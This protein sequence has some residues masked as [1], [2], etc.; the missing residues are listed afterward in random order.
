MDTSDEQSRKTSDSIR[1]SFDGLSKMTSQRDVQ[2]AKALEKSTLIEVGIH[3]DESE[4]Q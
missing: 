2:D 4:E 1:K 3:I